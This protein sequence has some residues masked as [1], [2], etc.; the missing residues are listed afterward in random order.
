MLDAAG[1]L[2]SLRELRKAIGEQFDDPGEEL[3]RL[4]YKTVNPGRS[5]TSNAREQFTG[6]VRRAM[7]QFVS[8]R[9]NG[10]LRHALE[11]E[12][13]AAETDEPAEAA[14]VAPDAGI[15]TTEEEIEGYHI[16]KSIA[17]QAVAPERVVHRDTKSYM[18]V[19][20]DD[21]NRKPICRLRFNASQKYIGLLDADKNETRHAV[22]TL[23]DLYKFAD[24]IREAAERY[25]G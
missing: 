1:E 22:E 6:L 12:T 18:G 21:N 15:E 16:V 25:A 14:E 2:K 3:V 8:E 24:Q 13:G 11:R 7:Q 10:R 5:F 20:L 23:D 19:L 4:F 17:R 9:V